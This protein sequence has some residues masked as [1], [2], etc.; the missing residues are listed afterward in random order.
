MDGARIEQAL[1]NL[2]ANAIQHSPEGAQV[3]VS[4]AL[5]AIDGERFVRCA[6]EDQGPGLAP[7]D[8]ARVFEQFFTRRKGGT[9][10]GLAI[11]RRIV[12]AHGGRAYAANRKEGG[13]RFTLWLPASPQE[14]TSSSALA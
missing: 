10:L 2:L 14:K 12:A 6:V 4:G 11:V 3:T 1:E 9:G 7:E 5:D 8:L 13:A